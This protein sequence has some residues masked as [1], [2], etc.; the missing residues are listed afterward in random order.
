MINFVKQT[1][2]IEF[3]SQ[4]DY[5]QAMILTDRKQVKYDNRNILRSK[6]R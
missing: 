4:R 6:M 1:R 2:T 5:F 3:Y